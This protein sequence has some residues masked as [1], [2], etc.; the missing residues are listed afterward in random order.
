MVSPDGRNVNPAY[1]G[2]IWVDRDTRRILRIEQRT[3]SLPM[4]YPISKVELALNYGFAKIDGKSYLLPAGSENLG[5]SRGSGAC[6]RNVIDFRDYRKFTADSN[7]KF[8][9]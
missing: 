6:T 2:A 4:D 1:E 3:T 7:I 9:Q 8:G 5:C